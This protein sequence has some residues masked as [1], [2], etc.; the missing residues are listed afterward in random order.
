MLINPEIHA[1]CIL[2]KDYYNIEIIERIKAD[3]AKIPGFRFFISPQY[4]IEPKYDI[5]VAADHPQAM[6]ATINVLSIKEYI[7]QISVNKV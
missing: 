5:Y 7:E 3:I 2:V 4:R 1:V 6:M